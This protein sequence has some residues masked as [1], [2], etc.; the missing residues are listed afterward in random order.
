[1]VEPDTS[2]TRVVAGELSILEDAR[3]GMVRSRSLEL[4]SVGYQSHITTLSREIS[5]VDEETDL[6]GGTR[7][8]YVCPSDKIVR[9]L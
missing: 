9:V 2:T 4:K 8:L 6:Q 1:M 3:P 5:S 7:Y